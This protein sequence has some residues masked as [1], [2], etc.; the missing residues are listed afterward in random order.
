MATIQ[1]RVDQWKT[2]D[3]DGI[4][5]DESGFDFKLAGYTDPDMRVRQKAVINYTHSVGLKVFINAFDPDDIFTKQSGNPLVLTA[6][7]KYLYESYIFSAGTRETFSAYR[8]KVDKLR[9]AIV[10]TGIEVYAVSTTVAANG[11][12]V[13]A[14]FDFLTL[15]AIADGFQGISWGTENFSATS[16]AMPFRT[17]SSLLQ[18]YIK[19]P[20]PTVNNAAGTVSFIHTL[21]SVIQRDRSTFNQCLT[22]VF[23]D[24]RDPARY[25]QLVYQSH[26]SIESFRGDLQPFPK[27][28]NLHRD[29]LCP[30]EQWGLST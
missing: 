17:N 6:G 20:V 15:S 22:Q 5:F 29:W 1:S 13:Q 12:F 8:T 27:A 30:S 23:T 26:L 9:S 19:D 2:L 11:A 10:Q 18:N 24:C 3:A 21:G 16:A 28:H 25:L 4:F 14:D 7:D